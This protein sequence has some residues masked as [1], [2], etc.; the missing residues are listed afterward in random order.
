MTT[1]TE[2]AGVTVFVVVVTGAVVRGGGVVGGTVLVLSM[3]VL[4][5]VGGAAVVAGAADVDVVENVGGADV[6]TGGLMSVRTTSLGTVSGR[7][8]TVIPVNSAAR[9]TNTRTANLPTVHRG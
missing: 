5:V 7:P 8:A 9:A 4:A 3:V 2:R 6:E 1:R